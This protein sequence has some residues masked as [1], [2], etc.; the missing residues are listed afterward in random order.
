MLF[1]LGYIAGIATTALL[2]GLV[3][4]FKKPLI[5]MERTIEKI[6]RMGPA[7]KGYVF[8]PEDEADEIRREHIAKNAAQGKDTPLSE[9]L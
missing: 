5:V 7:P 3:A 1:A 9:L 4:Y 6:A 8:E 2:I